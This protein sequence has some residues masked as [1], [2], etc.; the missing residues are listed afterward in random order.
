MGFSKN[1]ITPLSVDPQELLPPPCNVANKKMLPTP[2]NFDDPP[3][4]GDFPSTKPFFI[5]ALQK[6]TL[7]KLASAS[8]LPK[9]SL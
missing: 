6:V 5:S 3:Q 1:D 9:A 2:K 7:E 4:M 8:L